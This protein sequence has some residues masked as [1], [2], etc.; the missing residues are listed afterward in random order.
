MSVSALVSVTV[1]A[2]GDDDPPSHAAIASATTAVMA[3][4]RN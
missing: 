1:G 3:T 2:G 4:L